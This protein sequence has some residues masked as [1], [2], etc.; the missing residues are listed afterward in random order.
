VIELIEK[1][2]IKYALIS[3]NS[4]I[5]D[6]TIKFF[7]QPEDEM[8]VGLMQRPAGYKINPHIH[9]P[10]V[11]EVRR[12]SEFLYIKSGLILV[13]FYDVDGKK[14]TERKICKDQFLLQL[15]GGHSFDFLE[16]TTIL[17]VKQGPFD[18]AEKVV[19]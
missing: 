17:E 19:L 1:N 5:P 13:H 10:N 6:N 7:S 12:T 18:E 4:T 8:Q 14:I 2:G 11:R 9:R 16:D 3:K 15:N